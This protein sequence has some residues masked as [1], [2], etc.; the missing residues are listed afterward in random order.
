M[1]GVIQEVKNKIDI[2][3]LVGSYVQ[4]KKA[5]RNFKASCPFHQEKSASFVVSPDRQIWHCFGACG[6]GGDCIKFLMKWENITFFEALKELANKAGVQIK[7]ISFEDKDWQ[8]KEK[9]LQ[10]NSLTAEFFQYILQKTKFGQPALKYL[11]SR[12]LS[13]GIQKLFQIG[14]APNSWDSLLKFLYKKGFTPEDINRSGVV[15]K[16]GSGRLYDRFRGR[17]MFPIKDIRGNI[18]G[19]SGRIIDKKEGDAKY[20]NT[21]ETDVYHKRESLFGIQLAKDAI[22]KENNVLIVEGELDMISPY[23]FSIENVVAVKGSAL[24]KDQLTVLKRLTSRITFAFDADKAGGEAIKKAI[25]EAEPMDFELYVLDWG[26]EA[27]DPDEMVRQHLADFKTILKTPI[28]IYD[29]IINLAQKK[30]PGESAF[31]KKKIGEEVGPYISMIKN[32][33]ISAHYTKKLSK[34]LEISEEALSSL[35]RQYQNKTSRPV[36]FVTKESVKKPSQLNR[37]ELMEKYLLS[38]IFQHGEVYKMIDSIEGTI[39]TSDFAIPAYQKIFQKFLEYRTTH[40]IE[41]IKEFCDS[42][43]AELLSACNE[44]FLYNIEDLQ[45]LLPK[46]TNEK[47]FLEKIALE[48]KKNALKK[49]IHVL[50]TKSGEDPAREEELATKHS[51]LKEVERKMN[52]L[53]NY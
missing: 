1:E 25:L 21:P 39:S 47:V 44:L 36:S 34:I 12:G 29:F 40:P 8:K 16:N 50:L 28:S 3:E 32:P 9:I 5:G 6:E 46:N 31:D 52:T 2:V 49:D 48:I 17:V 11:E 14:Y 26:D 4:L 27:K 10:I 30:Y 43:P 38:Y 24:T 45:E 42:L 13:E 19:F 53:Y 15:V 23:Q 7:A 20:L 41:N 18:I 35:L 33:I 51:I 37:F 22:R